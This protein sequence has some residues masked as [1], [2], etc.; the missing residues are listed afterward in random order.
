[1]LNKENKLSRDIVEK[2]ELRWVY[3]GHREKKKNK[4]KQ[5]TKVQLLISERKTPTPELPLSYLKCQVI[6]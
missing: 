1:M 5:K 2:Q 3:A 6:F 4:N